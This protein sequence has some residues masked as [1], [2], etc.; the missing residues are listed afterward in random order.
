[1]RIMIG[2]DLILLFSLMIPYWLEAPVG[3]IMKIPQ[4]PGQS[5]SILW[6][7]KRFA[8]SAKYWLAK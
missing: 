4:Y 3:F 1:M 5:F 2:E 7:N 6:E 8:F